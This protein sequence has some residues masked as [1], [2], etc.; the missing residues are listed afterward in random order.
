[1]KLKQIKNL[2][3]GTI[4][5]GMAVMGSQQLEASGEM[6]GWIGGGQNLTIAE[7]LERRQEQTQTPQAPQMP[8]TEQGMTIAQATEMGIDLSQLTEQQR[9]AILTEDEFYNS[10]TDE[11]I[12]M[13]LPVNAEGNAISDRGVELLRTAL[14]RRVPAVNAQMSQ[15]ELLDIAHSIHDIRMGSLEIYSGVSA[16][17]SGSSLENYE[18]IERHRTEAIEIFEQRH[19]ASIDTMV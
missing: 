17:V 6:P 5:V 18:W 1:M 12:F 8:N 11:E 19:G 7:M 2:A 13:R 3:M 15:Q 9:R 14:R 16:P 4:V 10:L